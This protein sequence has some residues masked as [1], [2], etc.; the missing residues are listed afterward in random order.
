LFPEAIWNSGTQNLWFSGK[1]GNPSGKL[2]EGKKAE[3][4]GKFRKL[5]ETFAE[6]IS[7]Y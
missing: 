6:K 3:T 5:P 4:S 1:G 7:I 2:P